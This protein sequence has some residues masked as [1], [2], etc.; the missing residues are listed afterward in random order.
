MLSVRRTGV[1][2]FALAWD[3]VGAGEIF[4][5]DMEEDDFVAVA[6]VASGIQQF[7]DTPPVRE[8]GRRTWFYKI[9]IGGETIGPAHA[10]AEADYIALEVA[11]LARR[12]IDR[13][14]QDSYLF[15]MPTFGERCT[16]CWD[17]VRQVRKRSACSTC[18]GTGFLRGASAPLSFYMSYGNVPAYPERTQLGKVDFL[19]EQ[20]WTA[21]YP[22][23]KIGDHIVRARDLEVFEVM[24]L[25][26]T[27]RSGTL[28]R[29]NAILK[30]IERG[31]ETRA[32]AQMV[33]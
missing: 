26:P 11:R 6:T 24:R 13:I 25:Q 22:L 12:Q 19:Q 23:L 7:E 29:Q 31:S 1:N 2:T 32:Y 28:L 9:V 27:W 16:E 5:S 33:L 3:E 10:E 4:R 8:S 20:A 17:A 21:N 18:D 15:S 14:G 30:Q